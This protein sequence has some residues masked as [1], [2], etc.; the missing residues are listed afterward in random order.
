[1]SWSPFS[2]IFLN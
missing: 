1:M 2:E